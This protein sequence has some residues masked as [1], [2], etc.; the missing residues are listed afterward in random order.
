MDIKACDICFAENNKLSK[1]VDKV[2]QT[3]YDGHVRVTLEVCEE[4]KEILNTLKPE[5]AVLEIV[6][7]LDKVSKKLKK[8][9]KEKENN[10]AAT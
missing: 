10:E 5:E 7:I 1:C 6:R 9:L 8:E 4:H 3:Y 2:S